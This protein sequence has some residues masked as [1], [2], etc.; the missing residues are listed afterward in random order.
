MGRRTESVALALPL[1]KPAFGA[2]ARSCWS[3]A[4]SGQRGSDEGKH[5]ADEVV[6]VNIWL[7]SSNHFRHHRALGLR[8]PVLIPQALDV[9]RVNRDED[10]HHSKNGR[11]IRR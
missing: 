4:G 11:P 8:D 7:V 3:S 9:P 6:G 2:A 1:G 5:P 10:P